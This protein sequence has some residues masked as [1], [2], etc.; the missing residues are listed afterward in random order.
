MRLLF[1]EDDT[2]LAQLVCQQLQGRGFQVDTAANGED[3]LFIL[4]QNCYDGCILDRMLPGLDGLSLLKRARACGVTTPVLMLT[5]MSRTEDL[6]AG[7]EGGADD[8]L[9]KPFAMQELLARVTV[10]VRHKPNQ[11]SQQRT[12]GDLTL[13]SA[14]MILTGPSGSCTLTAREQDMLTLLMEKRGEVV[15]R[16]V[17]FGNVWGAGADVADSSL[18]T[19]IY[20][21]RR[22]LNSVGS[23]LQLTTRRGV[24]YILE[25]RT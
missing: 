2:Q 20:F 12:A 19:Y 24:G 23:R 25:E 6:V 18:D 22:R 11:A 7:L 21:L 10:L 8:Y 1:I 16:E 4:R 5:A 9:A 14:G 15:P 3:G 17:F 13:D